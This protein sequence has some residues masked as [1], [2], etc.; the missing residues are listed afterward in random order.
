LSDIRLRG[1]EVQE[2]LHGR[3]RIEHALVHVD[4]DHLRAVGHL[5]TRDGECGDVVAGLDELAELRGS[6]DVR[7]LADVDEERLRPDV[8]RFK[9]G[10]A[11]T[12][13]QDRPLSRRDAADPLRDVGDVLGRRAAAAAHDVD[14]PTRR[15]FAELPC[16]LRRRLV[17]LAKGIR[18]AGIGVRADVAV[19]DARELL[20]VSAELPR[21]ERA[22]EADRQRLHVAHGVPESLDRL[23]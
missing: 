1:D 3:L 23:A 10:K 22:I 11:G 20:D 14:Q 17:V 5:I 15:P 4:V 19:R 12:P 2:P 18:Q 16:G 13:R 7:A 8:E 9:S 21:P 6:G